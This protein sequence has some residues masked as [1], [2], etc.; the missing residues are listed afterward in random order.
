MDDGPKLTLEELVDQ[1][2]ELLEHTQNLRRLSLD[3]FHFLLCGHERLASA[4]CRLRQLN[5][6]E[7]EYVSD[8]AIRFIGETGWNLH[9]LHLVYDDGESSNRRH[10][11]DQDTTTLSVLLHTLSN[12]PTLHTL[13][14]H[15]IFLAFA[16]RDLQSHEKS[17]HPSVQELI[18]W[19]AT[20][21]R[22]VLDFIDLFPNLALLDLHFYG[23]P[24]LV[25]GDAVQGDGAAPKHNVQNCWPALR[26]L[27]L[28]T[29][30]TARCARSRLNRAYHLR[31]LSTSLANQSTD[32]ASDAVVL[33]QDTL[34]RVSPVRAQLPFKF[35]VEPMPARLWA[36]VPALAPR[37]RYL[38]LK[39]SLRDIKKEYRGGHWLAGIPDALRGVPLILLRLHLPRFPLNS[40]YRKGPIE[41]VAQRDLSRELYDEAVATAESLPARLADAMPTLRIVGISDEGP[42]WDCRMAVSRAKKKDA[43][44]SRLQPSRSPAGTGGGICGDSTVGDGDRSASGSPASEAE[45]EA[46]ADGGEDDSED[47]S[48]IDDRYGD[49]DG[50]PSDQVF[51]DDLDDFV[52][53]GGWYRKELATSHWWRTCEVDGERRIEELSV[54]QGQSILRLLG[55]KTVRWTEQMDGKPVSLE[56]VVIPSLDI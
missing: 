16:P 27:S 50:E 47:G 8:Y 52:C 17:L 39:L 34:R 46:A 1:I 41:R 24:A 29:L 6:V 43:S 33:L 20:E 40:R 14:I 36:Q 11:K 5:H 21:P 51:F 42:N 28:C 45:T 30:D 53:Q 49:P 37:L 32:D 15:N 2:S 10:I 19:A 31:L 9:T 22:A 7:V 44:A 54:E 55:D 25:H 12:L 26:T 38:E 4:L 23:P 3:C 35:G 48:V 56:L 13:A 18:I